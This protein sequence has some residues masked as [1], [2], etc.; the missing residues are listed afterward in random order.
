MAS[1]TKSCGFVYGY[2]QND[3]CRLDLYILWNVMQAEAVYVLGLRR[4]DATPQYW[5]D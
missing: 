4:A 2:L 5:D 1:A 3:V